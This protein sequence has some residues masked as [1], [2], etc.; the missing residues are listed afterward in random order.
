MEIILAS[1]NGKELEVFPENKLSKG[2]RKLH[3]LKKNYA[4]VFSEKS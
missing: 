3:D 1:K 2:E 4:G